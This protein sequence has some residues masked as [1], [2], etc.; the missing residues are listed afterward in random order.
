MD[1]EQ[2]EKDKVNILGKGYI[3]DFL[4]IRP[5]RDLKRNG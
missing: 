5:D 4:N 3:P 1:A 2:R